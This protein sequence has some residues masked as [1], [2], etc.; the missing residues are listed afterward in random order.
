MK[1]FD[2]I[3]TENCILRSETYLFNDTK[4][5]S[6]FQ[7]DDGKFGWYLHLDGYEE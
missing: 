2:K 1:N 5:F 4:W 7:N 3:K 6:E